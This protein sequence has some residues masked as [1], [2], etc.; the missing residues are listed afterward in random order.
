MALKVLNKINGRLKSFTGKAYLLPYL[1]RLLCNALI[2]PH[3]DY[4]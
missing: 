4:A 3:F 1:K 2:Q